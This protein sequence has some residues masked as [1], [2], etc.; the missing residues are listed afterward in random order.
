M[1]DFLNGICLMGKDN[2]SGVGC[3]GVFG[4]PLFRVCCMTDALKKIKRKI[5]GTFW[6]YRFSHL[7]IQ[8]I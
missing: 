6:Q 4:A 7:S 1:R 3:G 5:K 2:I 8:K